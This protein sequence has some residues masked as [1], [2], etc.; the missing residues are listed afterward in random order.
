[1]CSDWAYA[2]WYRFFEGLQRDP[3]ED[4]DWSSPAIAYTHTPSSTRYVMRYPCV[5]KGQY[6]C[7]HAYDAETPPSMDLPCTF[8]VKFI[9]HDAHA[10]VA[11]VDALSALVATNPAA[12]GF[13][14]ATVLRHADDVAE[15]AMPLF[16]GT[17]CKTMRSSTPVF[18]V[19]VVLRL[20]TTIDHLW[21]AG[22]AYTDIKSSNILYACTKPGACTVVLGDLGSIAL[23]RAHDGT[24]PTGIFTFPPQRSVHGEEGGDDD[25]VVQP[26]EADIVWSL[27]TLLMAMT[28]GTDWIVARI[29]GDA[30]RGIAQAKGGQLAAA[31]RAVEEDL[32]AE[33]DEM[34]SMNGKAGIK[35]ANAFDVAMDAWHERRDV[36][37]STLCR[38][39]RG[40]SREV[41]GEGFKNRES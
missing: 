3:P 39:L 41:Q 37:I 26:R 10:E 16:A 22:L 31:F 18:A 7:V 24:R 11:A 30:L 20:A 28:L 34:R 38:V 12:R 40:Q 35:C 29:T 8:C 23:R 14:P 13:V 33:A 36:R 17:L 19:A 2:A 4:K 25:G 21:S 32:E 1:M 15:V 9:T 27:G 5:G 6:G